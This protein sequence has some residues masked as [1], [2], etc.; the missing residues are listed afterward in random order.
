M[1][2]TCPREALHKGPRQRGK[3]SASRTTPEERGWSEQG[4]VT[5]TMWELTPESHVPWLTS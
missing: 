3:A 4:W 2:V 1:E 5:P